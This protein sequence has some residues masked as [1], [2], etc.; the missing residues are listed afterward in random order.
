MTTPETPRARGLRIHD[1]VGLVVGYRMAALLARSLWPRTRPLVGIPAIA[2]GLEMLWL[3]LAMSGPIILLLDR[4]GVPAPGGRPKRPARPGR[5]IS[6]SEPAG[7]PVGRSLAAPPGDSPPRYTRAEL[8]WLLIGGYWIALTLF[9]V[10]ARSLDTPWALAC[11]LQFVAAMGVL[12][13]VPRRGNP[14]PGPPS[15]THPAAVS[16]LATWPIAWIF[17][18]ALSGSY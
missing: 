5:R 1:L 13:V 8:A 12:V 6:E 2:L 14:S 17:L 4:R 18:I 11:L 10:P 15:W 16:L 9:V 7:P 3:G